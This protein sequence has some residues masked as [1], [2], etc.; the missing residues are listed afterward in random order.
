MPQTPYQLKAPR[1]ALISDWDIPRGNTAFPLL[2]W[3]TFCFLSFVS[4]YYCLCNLIYMCVCG[5]GAQQEY[6]HNTNPTN[7][8]SGGFGRIFQAVTWHRPQ[9]RTK[10]NFSQGLIYMKFG[11][12]KKIEEIMQ[13]VFRRNRTPLLHV[14]PMFT[15]QTMKKK[16]HYKRHVSS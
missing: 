14:Q 4:I 5:G 11:P 13:V 15:L 3:A 2:H 12:K 9:Q 7:S 6:C 10:A 1:S 16:S 8:T